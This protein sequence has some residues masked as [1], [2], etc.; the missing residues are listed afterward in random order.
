L[1]AL[2]IGVIVELVE[3]YIKENLLLNLYI[4]KICW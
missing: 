2:S 1:I 4:W 3:H